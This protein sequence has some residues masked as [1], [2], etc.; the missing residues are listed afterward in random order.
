M[1]NYAD[2]V[3]A[4]NDVDAAE[5]RAIAA[6]MGEFTAV[7]G[8]IEV[9]VTSAEL[10][11]RQAEAAVASAR[12]DVEAVD[13]RSGRLW[14]ELGAL[15]GRRGRWLGPV[16]FPAY[17]LTSTDAAGKHLDRAAET[18]GRSVLGLQIA[19][20]PRGILPMLPPA[21]A[22]AALV[23]VLLIRGVEALIGSAFVDVIAPILIFLA[24][25]AG[26]PLTIAWTRHRYGARPDNGALALT[27]LGGMAATCA[28]SALIH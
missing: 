6:I 28:F 2:L 10:A 13:D 19:P 20:I 21:G 25:F 7:S 9:E 15:L 12:R 24:P 14:A 23:A 8:A 11:V 1:R 16:P 3:R 27:A 18:I 5:D 22:V 26:V 17:D 4:L